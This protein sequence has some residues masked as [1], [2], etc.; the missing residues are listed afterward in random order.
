MSRFPH[1]F[2]VYVVDLEPIRGS[3]IGKARP[4]VIVS[5]DQANRHLATVLIAPL[6]SAKKAYSSRVRCFFDGKEGQIAIDQIRT[7]DK[8]RLLKRA[9]KITQKESSELLDRIAGYFAPGDP[10]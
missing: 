6:M 1:R 2:D 4:C 9:G 10:V 5:P 7:V 3:E 8:S